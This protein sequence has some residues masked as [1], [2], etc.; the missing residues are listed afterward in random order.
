[1]VLI[2]TSIQI[3]IRKDLYDKLKKMKKPN[4]SFSDIIEEQI[5]G[6]SNLQDVIACYGIAGKIEDPDIRDAYKEARNVINSGLIRK[7]RE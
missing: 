5:S 3:S 6:P 2:L 4:Q 7:S 1:M